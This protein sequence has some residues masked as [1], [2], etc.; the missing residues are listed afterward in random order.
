MSVAS[1]S[2]TDAAAM[3]GV[4]A[5]VVLKGGASAADFSMTVF[6]VNLVCAWTIMPLIYLSQK[7]VAP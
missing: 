2:G 5:V 1:V 3:S 7:P 6:M 4:F